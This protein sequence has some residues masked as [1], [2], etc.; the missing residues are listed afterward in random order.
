MARTILLIL[1]LIPA[2]VL[3]AQ[4]WKN[5]YFW[6]TAAPEDIPFAQSEEFSEI[7]FTGLYKN[8]TQADT[9]YP[10]WAEDGNLYSP[11]T[12]GAV[13]GIQSISD[14]GWKEQGAE[15]TGTGQAVISGDDPMNLEVRSLGVEKAD[16]S[17]YL[18]RYPCGS[19]VY[20]GYWYYGTYCLGPRSQVIKDDFPYNWPWLGPFVGF[21][22]SGDYGKT[23][24]DCPHTPEKPLFGENGLEAKP[25]KIGAPHFIDFGSNMEHSPDGKAYLVAHGASD[26]PE[27]RRFAYNS[28]ITGD[29]I[30]LI[31]ITPSPENMNDPGAYEFFAGYDKAGRPEWTADFRAIQPM[32]SWKDR[33]GCVT[34]SYNPPLQKYFMCVT[35]GSK[36]RFY[37]HTSILE[38]DRPEGPWKLVRYFERFGEQAYF[39]NIPSKFISDDGLTMWLCYSAN[40]SRNEFQLQEKPDGSRYALSLH[41]I[42]LIRNNTKNQT[43][44]N[45]NQADEKT[46]QAHEKKNQADETN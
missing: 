20:N 43:D 38:A 2:N 7:A 9:W 35:D 45:K 5:L 31:R 8:Y 26:G 11:Y 41:E 15:N 13:D 12:D 19:L 36:T 18:G 14:G 22:V 28:W 33:L 24:E 32:L 40:F 17:P 1:I 34:V 42:K 30:Y 37:M 44:E 10:S 21:R 25:V 23:W 27:G 3:N 46:N 6:E 4:P 16:A 39:V 29:E